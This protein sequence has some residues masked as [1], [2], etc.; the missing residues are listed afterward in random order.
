MRSIHSAFL[1]TIVAYLLVVQV[2]PSHAED[3]KAAIDSDELE[4]KTLSEMLSGGRFSKSRSQNPDGASSGDEKA[5]EPDVEISAEVSKANRQRPRRGGSRV[6]RANLPPKVPLDRASIAK[7]AS[8]SKHVV[9][10]GH[11]AGGGG[12][13]SGSGAAEPLPA[14]F[15]ESQY[16]LKEEFDGLHKTN[17]WVKKIQKNTD[18]WKKH[19]DERVN[20]NPTMRAV[21]KN[22]ETDASSGKKKKEFGKSSVERPSRHA[23]KKWIPKEGTPSASRSKS[24]L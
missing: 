21:R 17:H 1:A 22:Q 16:E 24:E 3:G 15:D 20:N 18:G 12:D 11:V 4:G 10:E 5:N 13:A 19:I 8:K 7:E 2:L 6:Q 14:D 23:K 9:P